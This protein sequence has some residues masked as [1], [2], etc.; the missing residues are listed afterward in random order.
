MKLN[1]WLYGVTALAM[2]AACSDKDVAPDSGGSTEAVQNG[3]IGV[4]IQLPNTPST[5][6]N[7]SFDDGAASEY[8]VNDAVLVLFQGSNEKTAKCFGAFKLI[9]GDPSNEP[10][11]PNQVTSILTRVANVGG[12]DYSATNHLYALVML[13]GETT[14]KKT[15]GLYPNNNLYQEWMKGKTIQDFQE[16]DTDKSLYYQETKGSGNA[17]QIFMTNS[18]LST[19]KGG[20]NPPGGSI[21]TL[22][23]LVEL[24]KDVYSSQTDA[25]A[26]PAGIIT[27]ER[28][29]GK[30][31][32]SSFIKTT[33]VIVTYNG[34]KYNLKVKDISWGMA[35]DMKK[36]YV[37][38]NTNRYPKGTTSG[39]MLWKWNYATTKDLPATISDPAGK[40]R[41]LGHTAI[42][43]T[44]ET[45]YYRP[46][47]CQVP[48][49]NVA[50]QVA[51]TDG[52][53]TTNSDIY[54]DKAFNSESI[55]KDI[56]VDW[57]TSTG[58][59]A[60]GPGAFY[61]YENTFPVK[62]MQYANTTRIGFWVTFDFEALDDAP[63]F[64]TGKTNFYISGAD[65][66]TIYVDD[67]KN[68]DPL[69]NKVVE[70]LSKDP[71]LEGI[72][73]AAMTTETAGGYSSLDI[74]DYLDIVYDTN[75][76]LGGKI[77]IA[78]IKLKDNLK[79]MEEFST[80]PVLGDYTFDIDT[81]NGLG[82]F[83]KY[84]G[85]KVFY[86]V[87]IK[88]FGDDLTPW[89]TDGTILKATSIKDSYGDESDT[90]RDNNY[91]GRYGIVRNNWY[92]LNISKITKLGDPEDPRLW[93]TNW[94]SKPDDN[95][96]E[97]IAVKVRILSWAKR[98]QNV[99]F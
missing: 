38:R 39:D 55:T 24:K 26:N 79:N 1:K 20:V 47:F 83:Y 19:V 44:D 31:T 66:S 11:N 74:W 3:F 30:I 63:Q 32:C 64:P 73:T 45:P 82:D 62:Y 2:L 69:T 5:R 65:K 49:Y 46:Y 57:K 71:K 77:K 27:V 25:L 81:L 43:T 85:G 68:R 75:P 51:N 80:N 50:K 13:N 23:V 7:D 28:A 18:P 56:V 36:S 53:G 95:K 98:I 61:P 70:E 21:A 91:L 41:M 4:R 90:N 40:Y 35:Q 17:S 15:N 87:R 84:D 97:Y 76:A 93:D 58:D 33:D 16:K 96:E 59:I 60:Q 92:D 99:E 29:V 42:S 48:G 67:N 14:S 94:P 86:E 10:D 9:D 37:V 88:H 12:I 52:E 6:A 78:S 89:N 8:S 72:L 54:E 34:F 22:P